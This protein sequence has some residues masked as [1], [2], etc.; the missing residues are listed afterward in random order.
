MSDG[1]DERLESDEGSGGL[2]STQQVV[3]GCWCG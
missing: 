2:S 3:E 1:G